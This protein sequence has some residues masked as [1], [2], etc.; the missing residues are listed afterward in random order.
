MFELIY[1]LPFFKGKSVHNPTVLTLSPKVA[2]IKA[3]STHSGRGDS[4]TS[5]LI[6]G[7]RLPKHSPAH[8]VYGEIEE[9]R[10][11]I[12]WLLWLDSSQHFLEDYETYLF[13]WFIENIHSLGT[14]CFTWGSDTSTKHIFPTTV[15]DSMDKRIKFLQDKLKGESLE[16]CR[17][18]LS[19]RDERLLRLDSVRVNFRKLESAYSEWHSI[20]YGLQPMQN[21]RLDTSAL[22]NRC[23]NYV[24]WVT[25]Y[26]T[27][28]LNITE[29]YWSAGVTEF[30]PPSFELVE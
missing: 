28:K 2:R 19:F 26:M 11:N 21:S 13:Q 22:L 27:L 8:R 14:Y 5:E 16:N 20:L 30:N 23:S 4:G 18:F 12:S 3:G 6:E 7:I 9:I 15:L 17:D 10:N 1:K 25:R 29:I 24:F